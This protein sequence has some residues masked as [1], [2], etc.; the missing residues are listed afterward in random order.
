MLCLSILTSQ[1]YEEES[2]VALGMSRA[3]H[4]PMIFRIGRLVI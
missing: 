2:C 4:G 1:V 3:M